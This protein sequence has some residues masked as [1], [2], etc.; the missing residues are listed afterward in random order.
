MRTFE[1][2]ARFTLPIAMLGFGCADEDARAPCG[3]LAV[4]T[5]Q[6]TLREKYAYCFPVGAAVDFRSRETH[7][8][9][10]TRHF[11]SVTPENEMKFD[12]FQRTEG[13][14]TYVGADRIV[15]LAEA[16]DLQIRGHTLVWHRQNPAWLFVD[17]D[18]DPVSGDVLL[19]RMRTHIRTVMGRYQGRVRVWDVVN[20]AI[21][22]DGHLRTGDEPGQ[23]QSSPW[24]AILGERYI[25]EAFRAA[26]EADPRA[27]LFYN[28]YYNYLPS[29]H[30]AIYELL[31]GLLAEGVPVHGVGLQCHLNIEPSTDPEH[32]SY[33]QTIENTEAAIELYASLGLEVQITEMD[34][35]VYVGGRMYTEDEFY[36][37]ETF[38]DA[39][40]QQQA[41]RYRAFFE[42]F[43]RHAD[44]IT[45]VT[46]WGVADDDT[47]LSEL[48]SGRTDF[49]LLFDTHHEPKRAFD[50]IVDF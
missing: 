46:L 16:N 11:D 32:H 31:E 8:D 22:D 23:D 34:V 18:G 35:S 9:L 49:P 10:I 40:E 20:E 36:T 7:A 6:P 50:A 28:D 47:W 38:T 14:F 15:E 29:K 13:L 42:L 26:H 30:Q 1:L 33:H 37:E 2:V 3:T 21:M 25:A 41:E 4:A 27:R 39:L 5:D 12:A 43:R 48:S 45:G 17:D 24:Y 44:A 19:E